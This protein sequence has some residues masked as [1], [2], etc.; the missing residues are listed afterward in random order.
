MSWG[1][2]EYFSRSYAVPVHM[3]REEGRKRVAKQKKKKG[4]GGWW[5]N[6]FLFSFYYLVQFAPLPKSVVSWLMEKR[7]FQAQ[8][9]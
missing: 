9:A 2:P 1:E 5:S 7:E 8:C 4:G 6:I 3:V